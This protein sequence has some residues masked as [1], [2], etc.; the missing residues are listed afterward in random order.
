MTIVFAALSALALLSVLLGRPWTTALAK[1]T[2]NSAYWDHP[3]FRETNTVM[4]LAWAV[5]FAVSAIVSAIGGALAIAAVA[6][7]NTVLGLLSP[8]LAK[9]YAAWR[10]PGQ[11]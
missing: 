1:R 7:A 11:T 2:T 6:V 4:S 10:A 8:R 3:L 5:L 9:T